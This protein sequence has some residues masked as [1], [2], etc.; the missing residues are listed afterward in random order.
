MD[1]TKVKDHSDLARDPNTNSIVNINS[2]GYAKYVASRKIKSE[3]NKQVLSMEE[4]LSNLKDEMNEIKSLLKELV[5]G[6]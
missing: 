2:T 1:L 3:K 5:N 6:K 4:D